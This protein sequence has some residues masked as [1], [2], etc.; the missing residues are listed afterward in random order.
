MGQIQGNLVTLDQLQHVYR[1]HSG[2][3]IYDASAQLHHDAAQAQRQHEALVD[4]NTTTYYL[5][6]ASTLLVEVPRFGPLLA[7]L[8][9]EPLHLGPAVSAALRAG[10]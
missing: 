4:Q 5:D 2:T 3:P 6:W 9:Y 8:P 10:C 1:F 7:V